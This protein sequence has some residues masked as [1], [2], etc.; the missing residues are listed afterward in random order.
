MYGIDEPARIYMTCYHVLRA[1]QDPRAQEI[2]ITAHRLVQERA[3]TITNEK[4]RRSFLENVPTHREI[5][6]EFSKR[7]Q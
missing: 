7:D 4:M 6:S 2:L 5:L 3:A 1:N